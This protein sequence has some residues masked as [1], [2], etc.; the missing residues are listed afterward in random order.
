MFG[1]FHRVV[2]VG[3]RLGFAFQSSSVVG[4]GWA[5]ALPSTSTAL[6]F[7]SFF[8]SILNISF[9]FSL[10]GESGVLEGLLAWGMKVE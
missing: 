5:I 6:F 8:Y 7:P 3:E 9:C 1:H 4:V 10:E 2:G